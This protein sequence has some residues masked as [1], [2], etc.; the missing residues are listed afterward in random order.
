MTQTPQPLRSKVRLRR[1]PVFTK[2]PQIFDIEDGELAV[3]FNALEPGLFIRDRDNEGNR[4]IRKIG[5]IHFGSRAPNADASLYD[6]PVNLSHGE[7]WVDTTD[8]EDKY[9][10]KVWNQNAAGGEG[11]W[12]VVG[13][14]YGRVDG[15][16]DQFKDGGDGDDYIHTDRARLKIN[17]KTALRGF[18][19]E[20]GDRLVI[21]ESDEFIN[22]VE[23]NASELDINSDKVSIVSQT[24]TPFQT[25]SVSSDVFTYVAHGLFNGERIYVYPELADGETTSPI[26]TGDYYIINATND[27]FQI[28]E[29]KNSGPVSSSGN[30]YLA[31]YKE[32]EINADANYFSSGNFAYK[33]LRFTPENGQI[34]D[35]H[36]DIYHNPGNG[37]VRIYARTGNTLIEPEGPGL[38]VEVK[39]ASSTDSIPAGT[40]V[41]ITGYD[42][43]NKLAKVDIAK[44]SQANTMPGAGITK[45]DLE[46]GSRGYITFLGRIEN[47]DTSSFPGSLGASGADEGKVL[48]VAFDGG[49]TLTPPPLT[50]GAGRQAI[51]ILVSQDANNGIIIVNNPAA[52]SDNQLPLP[53]GYV[54]IGDSDN[55]AQAHRLNLDSFQIRDADNEIKELALASNIKF[56]GY[57]FLYDGNE[58]SKVQSKV[59]SLSINLNSP[60]EFAIV[61]SFN[62]NSYRSAK[63]LVQI[64][65]LDSNNSHYEIS[66]ILIVHNNSIAHLTEFGA[67]N[68]SIETER[69]GTFDARISPEG[70]CELLFRKHPWITS[71]LTLR[72]LRTAILV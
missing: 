35:G 68:T 41:Y 58:N 42:V 10:F 66:E 7:T 52:F 3:N 20:D 15:Y 56:G 45:T 39:N 36:W 29:A 14:I 37:N 57:E 60:P 13:E 63:F 71:Q 50:V 16:L 49:L 51:A 12:I 1:S 62:A 48:Y 44:G 11:A 65:S 22:G 2:R 25:D 21:N 53:E 27:T 8:G 47:L 67:V 17:N 38:S 46:P 54:W 28:S 18:S 72:S 40:P 61:A 30:I 31:C 70:E 5:P 6:F 69:F 32:I 24:M 55:V 26:S 19:T 34:E 64:S 43:I 59:T 33:D 4:Q 9:L 23:V